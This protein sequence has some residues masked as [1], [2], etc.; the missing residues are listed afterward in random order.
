MDPISFNLPDQSLGKEEFIYTP[1]FAFKIAGNPEEYAVV[2][3]GRQRKAVPFIYIKLSPINSCVTNDDI[4]HLTLND[5]STI[6]LENLYDSNCDGLVVAEVDY[7][8]L[9]IL[10]EATI[11]NVTVDTYKETYQL[12]ISNYDAERIRYD[13]YCLEYKDFWFK[14]HCV[15]ESIFNRLNRRFFFK[16]LK[17]IFRK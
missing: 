14:I 5:N 3:L 2:Q 16:F 15:F 7:R 11:T 4:V 17:P 6:D 13:L 12:E 10:S 9:K 8:S 1:H